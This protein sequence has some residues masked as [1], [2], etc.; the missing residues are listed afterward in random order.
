MTIEKSECLGCAVPAYPCLG[1]LCPNRHIT[2]HVC[3]ECEAEDVLYDY[4][5]RELCAECLL[6]IVPKVAGT[7]EI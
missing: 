5:G 2:V 1:S 7:E 3:D 6:D 4:N